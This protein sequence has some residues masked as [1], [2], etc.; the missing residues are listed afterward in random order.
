MSSVEGVSWTCD[1]RIDEIGRLFFVEEVQRPSRAEMYRARDQNSNMK[2]AADGC[3]GQYR[4]LRLFLH[5]YQTSGS[6]R[7]GRHH[8]VVQRRMSAAY[9]DSMLCRGLQ[10]HVLSRET[11]HNRN[12]IGQPPAKK[13]IHDNRYKQY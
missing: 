10:G 1:C 6:D 8:C 4:L 5:P 11:G 13:G 12:I 2:T 7:D 9:S 3:R